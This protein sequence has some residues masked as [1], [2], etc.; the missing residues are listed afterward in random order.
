MNSHE[1][2]SLKIQSTHW[3]KENNAK[4]LETQLVKWVWG[5][6]LSRG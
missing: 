3:Y 5:V 6:E 1:V 2:W 4:C